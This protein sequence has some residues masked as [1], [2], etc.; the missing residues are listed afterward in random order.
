MAKGKKFR[1][2]EIVREI[3]DALDKGFA[4]FLIKTQ[5]KLS[6][7]APVDTG[8]FASSW[9]IGQGVPNRKVADQPAGSTP[10]TYRKG[11]KVKQGVAGTITEERPTQKI[12]IDSDWYLSNNLPYAERVCLDPKYAKGGSGGGAWFTTIVNNLGQDADKA[13]DFFLRKVK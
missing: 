1:G 6:K 2:A 5:G 11:V 7:N 13:F 4:R 9:F 10:S 3:D 12:T 8:R